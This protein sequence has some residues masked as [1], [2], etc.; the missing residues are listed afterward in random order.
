MADI[1]KITKQLKLV[2][3]FEDGDDRTIS[4]DNPRDDITAEE[5]QAMDSVAAG[6]LFGDKA[7]AGFRKWKSAKVV[8]SSVTYLDLTPEG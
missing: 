7:E 4:L 8:E 3:G 1:R 2:A 6:V 5:I